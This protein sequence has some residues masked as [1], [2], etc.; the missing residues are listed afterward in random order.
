[1]VRFGSDYKEVSCS[2]GPR[3]ILKKPQKAFSIIAPNW[4]FRIKSLLTFYTNMEQS[5]D[6]GLKREIQTLIKDLSENYAALQAHYQAVYIAY[7]ANPCSKE[8]EKTCQDAMA[9]I[10]D[11]EYRL[12]ELEV[13]SEKLDTLL[14]NPQSGGLSTKKMRKTSEDAERGLKSIL[15]NTKGEIDVSEAIKEIKRIIS[16]LR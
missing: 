14:I 5:V 13:K 2:D 6:V 11:K 15:A 8:A 10:R 16:K 12:R 3:Y 9:E 1:M 7:C 4:D